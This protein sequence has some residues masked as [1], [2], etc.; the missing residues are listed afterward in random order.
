MQVYANRK[1]C[2]VIVMLQT[3][4]RCDRP[5]NPQL[6]AKALANSSTNTLA[7]R[8]LIIIFILSFAF[9]NKKKKKNLQ[10]CIILIN[11]ETRMCF[12]VFFEIFGIVVG[13]VI[14]R[15]SEIF[16]KKKIISAYPA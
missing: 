12:R 16:Q 1:I 8:C 10:L 6:P 3:C 2:Y 13:K 5:L 7:T 4:H 11:N 9:S 14:L 15:I